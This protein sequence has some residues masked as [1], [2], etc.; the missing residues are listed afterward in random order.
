MFVGINT[1]NPTFNITT[2]GNICYIPNKVTNTSIDSMNLLNSYL[3]IID[4]NTPSN[5]TISLPT[6]SNDGQLINI[7]IGNVTQ[8]NTYVILD[9][10][11]NIIKQSYNGVNWTSVSTSFQSGNQ[12]LW[13]NPSVGKM[14]IIQPTIIGGVGPYT[15]MAYSLDGI[16]YISLGNN[17]FSGSCNAVAWNGSIWVAGGQGTNTLAYSYNGI[18]WNGVGS[19]IFTVACYGVTWNGTIWLATGAGG[20]TFAT[21]INGKTWAGVGTNIIDIS[22]ISSDWNGSAWVAVGNGTNNTIAYSSSTNAIAN[23]WV[24]LGKSSFTDTG[25]GIKWMINKWVAVGKGSNTF[26]YSNSAIPSN[27]WS[28]SS[29]NSGVFTNSA[30]NLFWNGNIAISVGSGPTGNTIATSTDGINWKGIGN[31]SLRTGGYGVYWNTQRWVAG[32]S[33]SNNIVYSY[34]GNTWYN[35]LTQTNM[36]STVNCVSSNSKLGPII[37]NG[38]IYLNTGDNLIVTSPS[39]YDSGLS[40]DTSISINMNLP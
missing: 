31:N 38:T 5:T 29:S 7:T 26:V 37:V 27:N 40:N 1:D 39:V 16:Y 34:N 11:T 24:G 23:S 25:Y 28:S 35:G 12:L 22:A 20:N 6:A 33:G 17:V 13:T 21:S 10:T 4:I 2:A 3:N 9:T 36:F 18:L 8:Q 30:N 19:S 32:G 14:N 15:T